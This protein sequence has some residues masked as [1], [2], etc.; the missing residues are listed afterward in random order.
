MDNKALKTTRMWHYFVDAAVEII[1]E[2]GMEAVTIRKVADRAG[3]TSATIYNYFDE[4]S[5]L[6]FFASMRYL[7]EYTKE[8]SYYMDHGNNSLEKYLKTWECFCK[9]SFRRPQIYKALFI[10]DLGSH[11]KALLETYYQ[12]NSNDWVN[13]SKEVK[14]LCMEY[15][16]GTRNRIILE[17]ASKEGLVDGEHLDEIN[18]MAILIW[19]G[20]MTT[21]LTDHDGLSAKEAAEKTLRYITNVTVNPFRDADKQTSI[22]K[23]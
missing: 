16:I 21:L 2:E 1:E 17:M 6:I 22:Q 12:M 19:K 11:P 7:K 3:Y 9:H 15:N 4:F 20:M 18:E 13:L 8:L 10:S 5:N 14:T 23:F